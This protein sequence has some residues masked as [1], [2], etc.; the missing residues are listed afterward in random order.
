MTIKQSCLRI[1]GDL[2]FVGQERVRLIVGNRGG[3]RGNIVTITNFLH[4]G[5]LG[6]YPLI[7]VA[8]VE[9]S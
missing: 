3:F 7:G 9:F 2:S 8:Q 1:S 5:P 6:R 4:V